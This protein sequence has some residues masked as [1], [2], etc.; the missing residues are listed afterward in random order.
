MENTEQEK[1]YEVGSDRLLKQEDIKEGM[2]V[3]QPDQPP[4]IVTRLYED[5]LFQAI[6][7]ETY[8]DAIAEL[9]QPKMTAVELSRTEE[10]MHD[11]EFEL[12]LGPEPDSVSELENLR[13]DSNEKDIDGPER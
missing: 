2:E 8:E 11:G 1:W 12:F 13:K 9:G 10:F 6:S 4:V 5:G 3:Y 7:R